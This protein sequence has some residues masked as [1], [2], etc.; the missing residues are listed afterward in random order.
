MD[1]HRTFR[2]DGSPPPIT[3]R[4]SCLGLPRQDITSFPRRNFPIYNMKPYLPFMAY[5][6]II[7]AVVSSRP[8]SSDVAFASGAGVLSVGLISLACY[9]R[10]YSPELCLEAGILVQHTQRNCSGTG[11]QSQREG[12]QQ[13]SEVGGGESRG[14]C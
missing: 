9:A 1:R 7:S 13:C 14:G 11:S 6:L 8:I 2:R 4:P 10:E 5:L 12:S 3:R